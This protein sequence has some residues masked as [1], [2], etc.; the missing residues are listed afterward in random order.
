MTYFNNMTSANIVK[1]MENLLR[2]VNMG[3]L[4]TESVLGTGK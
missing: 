2:T 4:K 1:R 3:K